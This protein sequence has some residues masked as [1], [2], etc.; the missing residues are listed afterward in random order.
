MQHGRDLGL[1]RF[2]ISTDPEP[3]GYWAEGDRAKGTWLW[4]PYGVKLYYGKKP[5]LNFRSQRAE[6]RLVP[7]LPKNISEAGRWWPVLWPDLFVITTRCLQ[8]GL[9]A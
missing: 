1:L 2:G 7:E 8:A 3:H 6:P 4:T 5:E 9:L